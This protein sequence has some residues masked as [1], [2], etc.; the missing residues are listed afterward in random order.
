MENF[1]TG[2]VN[3]WF[4]LKLLSLLLLG[5]YLIFALVVIKQVSVMTR[6]LQLGYEN[7]VKTLSY[8]HFIFA[9]LV[10]VAALTIL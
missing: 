9:T 5:M 4:L 8:I 2:V 1:L 10:F 7:I 3:I 6:T